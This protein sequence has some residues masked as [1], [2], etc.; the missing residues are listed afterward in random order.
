VSTAKNARVPG[1]RVRP[2][3]VACFF[4]L[5]LTFALV[6]LPARAA[7]ISGAV[8]YD[9]AV[10]ENPEPDNEGR[11]RPLLTVN[12][13]ALAY[14]AVWLKPLDGEFS[15][16]PVAP[17][18]LDAVKIEQEDY[19]FVPRVVT[20]RA[21]QKV[22][23]GNQDPAN[24]NVRTVARNPENGFNVM[25]PTD[26]R[27]V[28]DMQPEPGERPIRLDCDFHPWMAGWIYV[29]DH[30][31]HDAT[32]TDGRFRIDNVPPGNYLL[33]LQQPDGRLNAQAE[34]TVIGTDHVEVEVTFAEKNLGNQHPGLIR[35][36]AL[37][38]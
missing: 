22:S 21:G 37:R 35:E 8:R 25:T 3:H 16:A 1:T 7:T 5:S 38:E 6:T 19:E 20:V 24:H 36:I 27:Y 23:I 9:G 10:P 33:T 30:A 12:E 26:Q 18:D 31:W 17:A 14:V 4:F 28:R 2:R 34:I 29:F 32:R 15:P 11:R 13:R